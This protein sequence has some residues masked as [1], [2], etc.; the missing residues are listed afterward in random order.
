MD[1]TPHIAGLA[2]ELDAYGAALIP[3]LLSAETCAAVAGWYDE[4]SRFR[5]TVVMARHGF[6]RGEYRY[7]ANPL[8]D[9]I[10]SLRERFYPPLAAIANRWNA[11]LG[12]PQRFPSTHGEF[13][14]RCHAAGQ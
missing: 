10:A 11:A 7:F 13:L 12:E 8:P 6:G 14:A 5:S 4:Q 9:L 1:G 2:D 3:G